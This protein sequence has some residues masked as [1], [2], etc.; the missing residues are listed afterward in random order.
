MSRPWLPFESWGLVS[1]WGKGLPTHST[2]Q[3]ESPFTKSTWICW[4][5]GCA[6]ISMAEK[7]IRGATVSEPGVREAAAREAA[8]R[9]NSAKGDFGMDGAPSYDVDIYSDEVISEPYVH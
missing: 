8:A 4:H 6:T 9:N 1:L 5:I 7:W 2:S 3:D